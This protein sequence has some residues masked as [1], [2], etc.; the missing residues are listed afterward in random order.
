MIVVLVTA[1]VFPD[2]SLQSIV[3]S[4]EVYVVVTRT[5]I[6]SQ[7]YE[8]KRIYMLLL[9]NISFTLIDSLT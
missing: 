8:T 1:A 2:I 7:Y 4:L 6:I 3:M 5:V 9:F